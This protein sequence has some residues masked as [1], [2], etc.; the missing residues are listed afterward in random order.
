M[1]T[2]QQEFKQVGLTQ[3]KRE[4]APATRVL[5]V[6][7]TLEV[8]G[9]EQSLLD[10]VSRFRQIDP[11][12]C[13]L[14]AGET[15]KPQFINMG[16]P[17]WS[18]AIQKKYGFVTGIKKL[19]ALIRQE[20]PHL[21]VACLTRSELISRMV[22]RSLHIPVIGTFVSDLYGRS[23]NQS[24]SRKA[25]WGVTFFKWLNRFTA[26]YCTGFIANSEAIKNANAIQLGVP[27]AKIQ[28]INRG[29]DSQR[30]TYLPRT[31]VPGKAIR[32]LNVGRLVSVKGQRDLILAFHHFL[33]THP[34]A[35]LDIAGEGPERSA[36]HALIE[37]K[38]LAGHVRLLGNRNDI[39]ALLQEYDCFVFSS[40]SEGFSGAVVEAMLSGI[41]VLASDIPANREV[42]R[43]LETGYLF[44]SGDVA[45]LCA[46]FAWYGD[47]RQQAID[48][49]A[50]AQAY[51]REHFELDKIAAHLETYLRTITGIAI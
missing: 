38:Q 8:G 11:L 40:Y 6:I 9:A 23:Y 45:A 18:L 13:H 30:F 47:H 42:M 12:V 20:Q 1:L 39:P 17:V 51:A 7:D 50:E 2:Y 26:G 29:R 3:Q 5:F 44:P 49:A 21:V 43:H 31:I 16:I 33:R 24:L 37:S 35:Q 46:A 36:L 32:C 25:Q 22:C 14:Y 10:L 41:P 48:M 34:D 4:T 28:V 15:L 27:P 19:K